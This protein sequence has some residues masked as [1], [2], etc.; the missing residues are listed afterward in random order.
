M[1]KSDFKGY[2]KALRYSALEQS[3]R[4]NYIKYNTDKKSQITPL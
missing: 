1:R 4:T 3:I 2:I